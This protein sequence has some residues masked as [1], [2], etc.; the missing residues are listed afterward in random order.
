MKESLYLIRFGEIALKG[1]NRIFFE[2]LLR[3]NIKKKLLPYRSEL[4]M[5][6]GRVYLRCQ[7][8][9]EEAVRSVLSSTFGI[10]G[11][12]KALRCDKRIE[13]IREAASLIADEIA[14][15]G[16]LQSF[17]VSARRADKS[18]P[19]TSYEIACDI[20]ARIAGA[21]QEFH[22]DVKTPD[23]VLGVE[24]RE[25]AY[26]YGRMEKGPGGL[27]VGCAGKGVVL[28]SGGID[29][30]VAAF[31][32]AKRGLKLDAVYFHAYPY[33]SN[34]ALDKVKKLAEILAPYTGGIRLHVIPFTEAQIFM[35]QRGRSEELTLHMRAA[36][37]EIADMV[38][39]DTGAKALVTGEALSQVA[40][41]TIESIT[42]TG[43]FA[44]RP[45]F[46]PVIG[47]DKE[48]IITIARRIGT[49]ET[50][51]LPYEDC[52]TIFS[53]KHPLVHPNKEL[54]TTAYRSLSL[55]E[56]L[57]RAY[58]DRE[59]YLF[60]PHSFQKEDQGTTLPLG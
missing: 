21:H 30:P 29:S 13:E 7:E 1:D 6:S 11:F 4:R 35:K 48:E 14:S 46:R 16:K 60:P 49:F 18:F 26:I 59:V 40:S 36:M 32:M 5:H 41:Q 52:C 24:I 9:P 17:K 50:S 8:A 56:E 44:Q 45:I 27:P 28:L 37:V 47:L 19:M 42:L 22:V 2:R 33:T 57:K 54:L 39:A 25:A 34:E 53:P 10:V 58:E 20:G 3:K 31:L 23:W 12:T 55:D 51:I 38:A 43:S 15:D